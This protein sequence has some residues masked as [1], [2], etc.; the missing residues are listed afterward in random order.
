MFYV[1]KL[2]I[3]YNGTH[4]SGW[5]RQQRKRTVQGII[6]Q[7]LS[8]LF[9]KKIEID[10][11]GRTDRGVHAYGQVAT[12]GVETTIP[13]E[14][15]H[16][17]INRRMPADI[18]IVSTEIV[19]ESFH[20]R[21]SAKGKRYA[22]KIHHGL[23]KNPMVADSHL[24]VAHTLDVAKMK[25]AAEKL[26]GEKDFRS[27]MASGSSVK[28]TVREIYDISFKEANELLVIEFHGNGFLYNMVRIIV[29]MLLDVEA[30]R[31]PIEKIDQIIESKDRTQLK[32]TAPP[33]GLYLVKVYY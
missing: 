1:V 26:I 14:K 8:E 32:H 6:E 15:F 2:T 24:H 19:D 18:H 13:Q 31:L 33:E 27:F 12:F 16:L 30:S 23:E 25:L 9:R 17:L 20:A 5:Q 28:N 4:F 7:K 11:A 21:Y 29:G 10:G 22:Y 3:S